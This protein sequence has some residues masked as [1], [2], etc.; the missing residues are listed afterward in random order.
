[1]QPGT[2]VSCVAR[3]TGVSPSPVFRWRQLMSEGDRERKVVPAARRLE[4]RVREVERLIRAT[5][6]TVRQTPPSTC[7]SG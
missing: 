4:E 1:M 2:L 6:P 5:D 7:S 3:R